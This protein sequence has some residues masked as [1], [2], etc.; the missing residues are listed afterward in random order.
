[1]EN[2]ANLLSWKKIKRLFSLESKVSEREISH[3]LI[4]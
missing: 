1:M 2:I 3:L 4:D